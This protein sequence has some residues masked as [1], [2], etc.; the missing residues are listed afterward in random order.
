VANKQIDPN[1]PWQMG[2]DWGRLGMPANE[3]NPFLTERQRR[4]WRNGYDAAVQS[5]KAPL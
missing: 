4:E 5:E 2:Y 1:G 3:G